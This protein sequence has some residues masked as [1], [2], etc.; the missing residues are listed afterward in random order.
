MV[1]ST[2]VGQGE[3]I[4]ALLQPLNMSNQPFQDRGVVLYCLSSVRCFR[5]NK[6][7]ATTDRPATSATTYQCALRVE[8]LKPCVVSHVVTVQESSRAGNAL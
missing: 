2:W 7:A 5:E 3:S 8:Q 1:N 6:D 4:T